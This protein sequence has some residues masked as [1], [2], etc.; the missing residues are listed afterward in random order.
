MELFL[1][2]TPSAIML[3]ITL[4]YGL[5]VI[6]F[7]LWR[8]FFAD[9]TPSKE[10]SEAKVL[11][12]PPLSAVM[13]LAMFM[14]LLSL[15]LLSLV[16]HRIQDF[17]EFVFAWLRLDMRSL[18]VFLLAPIPP[19]AALIIYVEVVRAMDMLKVEVLERMIGCRSLA[20]V[21]ALRLLGMGYAA[22]V[23]ANALVA[24]GEEMG[25]RAYL[26]PSLASRVGLLIAVVIVG[27]VWGLWHTPLVLSIRSLIEKL[28]PW[29]STKLVIMNYVV[30]CTILSYPLY[31]LL[32]SSRSVLPPAAF[33]GTMNALWQIPQFVTGI[34]DK[35]RYRDMAKAALASIIAW[36]IALLV[37]LVL[38]R[39]V[40]V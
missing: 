37:T 17:M 3:F 20:S 18:V 26:T 31:L 14:P 10:S 5:T 29:A 33:H 19:I 15:Y 30:S 39:L 40:S 11:V 13:V 25:W 6:L 35:H 27:V 34:S 23:T 7:V 8:L 2:S 24:V 4:S 12:S 1:P 22:G 36:S 9:K 16:Y 21:R 32:A 38:V 28:F